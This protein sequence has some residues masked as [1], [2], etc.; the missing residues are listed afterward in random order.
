MR[1]A[2]NDR[3]GR[4]LRALI[5]VLWRAGLRIA[6][7]LALTESD[8]DRRRCSLTVRSGKGGRRR[9]VGI[10]PW[11][12][13][14]HLQ[15][16]IADRVELP[17][18]PLF[19]VIDRPTRGRAWSAAAVRAELREHAA[20]AGVRRRCATPAA[21]CARRRA[22]TRRHAT[23]DNPTSA[24]ALVCLHHV[25]LPAGHRHRGDHRHDPKQARTNDACQ[26]RA[27]A[28]TRTPQGPTA[29]ASGAP[30]PGLSTHLLALRLAVGAAPGSH[31]I[32]VGL[33]S[34][35]KPELP[36]RPQRSLAGADRVH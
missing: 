32:S 23:A 10:D 21:P 11:A 8:L 16:W 1:Q 33:R 20:A 18:G 5:V 26:R 4:R 25:G 7:A 19:C 15:P 24:G 27:P 29:G 12:W 9:E 2:R 14:E 34:G 31:R 22:R 35:R 28:L 36:G 6:E 30:A 17:V 13:T 3:H